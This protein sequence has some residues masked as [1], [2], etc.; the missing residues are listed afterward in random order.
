M[1]ADDWRVGDET[2]EYE[3]ADS[4]HDGARHH[5]GEAP[6]VIDV[7]PGYQGPENVA[8]GGVGVPDAHNEA[9]LPLPKPVGHHRHHPRPPRGLEYPTEEMSL[10]DGNVFF[11][12]HVK[13]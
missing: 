8:D 3:E 12:F 7:G 13:I 2:E 11:R 6:V 10:L 5:E 4:A 1:N 9:S